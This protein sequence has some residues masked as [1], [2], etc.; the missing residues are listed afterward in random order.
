[1]TLYF[2]RSSEQYIV[3]KMLPYAYRLD[4]LGKSTEDVPQLGIY[5]N[6]YGFTNKDLGLYAMVDHEVAGAIWSRK[7]QA[8]HACQAFIDEQTPVISM[9]VL[10][11]F[12]KQGV[13]NAMLEQFLQEASVLYKQVCVSVVADAHAKKI[14][15]KFGFEAAGENI[16]VVDGSK[17]LTLLKKLEGVSLVRPSDGYDPR[18][19]M[20]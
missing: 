6:F 8:E 16:S 3:N 1:M 2:L 19:W 14:Y 15:E 4:V 9:A 7:M 17:T 11:K 5:K 12:Q 13:A 18:R 20:D 10:P